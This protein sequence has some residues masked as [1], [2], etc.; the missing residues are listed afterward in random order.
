MLIANSLLMSVPLV[1]YRLTRKALGLGKALM[2]FVFYW[3]SIEYLHLNWE[4]NWPWLNMGNVFAKFPV[5]I[6][7]YEYTGML[8]GSLW[9]LI[10]NAFIFQTLQSYSQTNLIK[11]VSGLILPILLSIGVYFTVELEPSQTIEVV[12]VQPNVDPYHKFDEG[13]ELS[14]LQNML[15]LVEE[16]TSSS[17]D[18]VVFPETSI[19]EYIDEDNI[20]RYRSYYMLRDFVRKFPELHVVTGVSTYNFYEEGEEH[21][22]TAR[23]TEDGYYYES[24][25]TAWEFD[26][27]GVS[28]DYHKMK[29]VPGVEKM[30]YPQIFGFLEYFSIDMGGISGSLGSEDQPVVFELDQKP[31]VAPLICYES[32]FPGFVNQFVRKGAEIILVITND[33]WWKDTDGYKQHMQ[34]ARLRAIENRKDVVRSANTGI[35]CHINYKGEVLQKLGW[36]EQGVIHADVNTYDKQTFY[37]KYGDY[38]GRFASFLAIFFA[39]SLLVKR[40]NKHG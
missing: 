6:Q 34:Y 13:A 2:A 17:T 23:T 40:A 12:V 16:E 37:T 26:V 31:S 25:N 5:L 32:V 29:L 8:G 21:S 35:S 10:V 9:V 15:D 33:G 24:Y 14:N 28:N 30:P 18:L 19:V 22:P 7:W 38:I 4:I 39:L 3:L 1:F 20:K 11:S 27:H 36:W